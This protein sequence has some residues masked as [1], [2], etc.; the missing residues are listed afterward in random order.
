MYIHKGKDE[1]YLGMKEFVA[2]ITGCYL[3]RFE[4]DGLLA[5]ENF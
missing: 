3:Q 2:V 4:A 1:K 5:I